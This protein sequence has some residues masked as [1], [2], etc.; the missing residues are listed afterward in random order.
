MKPSRILE[1]L[2]LPTSEGHKRLSA[3]EPA[4]VVIVTAAS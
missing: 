3:E 2:I 4:L 1:S